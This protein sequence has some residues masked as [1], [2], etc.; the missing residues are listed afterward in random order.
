M[1]KYQFILFISA[2]YLLGINF[3]YGQGCSD[4]GFCTINS[5]K[6]NS[7]GS[8]VAMNNQV[9][10]GAFYGQADYSI[11]VYGTYLDYSR[12]VNDQFGFDARLTTLAQ[13]GNGIK[14]FG[15]SDLFVNANYKISESV[16]L[17]LGGKIP[18]SGAD[19]TYNDLPLPLDYQAS[20]G[21]FDLIFGI[22][23]EINKFQLVAAIQQPLTQ[24]DN[25][26]LAT[27]YPTGSELRTFQSTHT[28]QRSGDVLVR[29]S[30]PV[31]IHS[32]LKL[33]PSLLPI[34][35][36]NNDRYTDEFDVS[37]E[38]DGSRGLTLNGTMYLDYELNG[39]STIQINMGMPFIARDARPDGLTR[40][41]ITNLEY[42]IRF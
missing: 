40:H 6:P 33:T 22:G 30:Y 1:T 42:S 41:F 14:V 11:A 18:F 25:Q 4:A 5:F 35:H 32:K 26:F 19:K 37:R 20:L 12:Q 27:D 2:F 38:I 34:Y 10:I 16:T 15:L 29:I 13:N 17:T 21:T 3:S 23:Y 24:N 7:H 8:A 31:S 28:F 39:N 36:L 9:K